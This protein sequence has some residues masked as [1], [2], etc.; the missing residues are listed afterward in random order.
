MSAPT[1][2]VEP[3]IRM[4]RLTDNYLQEMQDELDKAP[5]GP[6]KPTKAEKKAARKEAKRQ[7]Q[8]ADKK[9]IMR[10]ALSRE[11]EMGKRM[12]KRGNEE[13]HE[14]CKEIKITELREEIVNWGNKA[15]R[16]IEGKNDHIKMLIEDMT[17]TQDRHMRC[18]SK[19]VEL[20]DHVRDCFHGMIDGIRNMYDQEA[21]IMLREY[22]DEVQR[23]TE[24]VDFMHQNSE[25]IIHA[26]N[27]TTRDQLNEDYQIFL[28][29]RDDRVNTEIENRF[30]IR[31]QVVLR[32]TDMQQ[33]LNDFVESL[34][35]TELDAHKYEKIRWLTERQAAFMDE[36][37]KL[38]YEEL[39]NINAMSDLN[40]EMLR[41]E[42]ENN[43]TL[44]DLRLEFQYFTRVRKKIEQNQE[45]DR[46]I[47]HEKLRILTGE[48]YDI[49]KQLE[50]HVKS[51]ELLLALSIT[52]RKLQ[53]ESEKVILGGEIVDETDLGAVDEQFILKTLN[54]KA[55][56]DITEAELLE[57]NKLLRNF[58]RR[59][60]MVEA[61][62]LLLLEE[63]HRLTEQNEGYLNFIKSMS[64]TENPEELRSAVKIKMCDNQPMTPH[65]F[66][67]KCKEYKS[68]IL[69][70]SKMA[71]KEAKWDAEKVLRQVIEKH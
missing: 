22:Y 67:T 48:C 6:R 4:T 64:V 21:E 52:C 57:Q 16:N 47:T 62:N 55:H 1:G 19:T 43:S 38:N 45:M 70:K 44:N 27:I 40:K 41:V 12:E 13:W 68:R 11:L 37:R 39:K 34:R 8:M 53:T 29:Q 14:M 59:Q 30:R 46:V 5:E 18:F 23:R 7:E 49:I 3:E 54:M 63:K 15:E 33:Q 9:L 2:A 17:Q 65:L 69:C 50:K 24:E 51:G 60:A 26:T 10:D 36:S 42:S 32:M 61:Q 28:E 58:W 25:N 35:S 56:V 20:I 71:H 66:Q 31:D